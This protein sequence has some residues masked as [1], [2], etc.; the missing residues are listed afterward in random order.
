MPLDV[1]YPTAC[2]SVDL[3]PCRWVCLLVSLSVCLACLPTHLSVRLSVCL[4]IVCLHHV[5]LS[6]S[7][8]HAPC[9]SCLRLAWR[10]TIWQRQNCMFLSGLP[11]CSA[12]SSVPAAICGWHNI[13][14]PRC[15][16]QFSLRLSAGQKMVCL[17]TESSMLAPTNCTSMTPRHSTPGRA[18][19]ASFLYQ[20]DAHA[21][22][23]VLLLQLILLCFG[24]FCCVLMAAE[25]ITLA[26]RE[27]TSSESRL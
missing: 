7:V 5:L 15:C 25:K 11:V 1:S 6:A 17:R 10:L 13:G 21:S 12:I 9:S 8:C 22:C 23:C 14:S 2:L 27:S 24:Q 16:S 4:L 26:A 19:A 3:L 18:A 20:T